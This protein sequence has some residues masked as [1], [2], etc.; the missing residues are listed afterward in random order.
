MQPTHTNVT[1]TNRA[2]G[3]YKGVIEALTRECYSKTCNRLQEA[4]QELYENLYERRY[5][6]MVAEYILGNEAGYWQE[7]LTLHEYCHGSAFLTV[8]IDTSAVAADRKIE[9]PVI[10]PKVAVD[11]VTDY[12]ME[13]EHSHIQFKKETLDFLICCIELLES[14][15]EI[16][17]DG[18]DG[19]LYFKAT[20]FEGE[21]VLCVVS[22]S[23][24][25]V[26]DNDAASLSQ[27]HAMGYKAQ[28]EN[29]VHH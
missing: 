21:G 2:V 20:P 11:W 23:Q 8:T 16:E 12:L 26:I 3:P 18:C 13:E 19:V 22:R 7:Q 9:T 25:A 28:F 6:G 4:I 27:L 15:H 17:L 14:T 29:V 1:L 5:D 10:S 24:Q